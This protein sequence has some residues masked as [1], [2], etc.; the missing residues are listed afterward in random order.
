MT[1]PHFSARFC[2]VLCRRSRHLVLF[3]CHHGPHVEEPRQAE[4]ASWDDFLQGVVTGSDGAEPG[5]DLEE[6]WQDEVLV[7]LLVEQEQEQEEVEEVETE[8]T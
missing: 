2:N 7:L 6:G 8:I 4:Q 3:L 1:P 5:E